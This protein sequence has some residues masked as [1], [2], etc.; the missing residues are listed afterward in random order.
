LRLSDHPPLKRLRESR[1][2]LLQVGIALRERYH[3]TNPAHLL[4]PSRE[5]LCRAPPMSVMNSRRF[6]LSMGTSSPMRYQ[7]AD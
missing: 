2:P 7:P 5:R 6:T 3:H 4:R 1:E